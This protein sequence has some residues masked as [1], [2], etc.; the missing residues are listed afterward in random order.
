MS[1]VTT[2]T[3]R[4]RW[5]GSART[6]AS[7]VAYSLLSRLSILVVNVATGII[8]ARTLGPAGR[9]AAAAMT[10]WPLVIPA[11]L[12]LGV[13]TALRY[14]IRRQ[15]DAAAEF[16]AAAIAVGGVLGAVAAVTGYAIVPH[17]LAHYPPTVVGFAQWMMLFAPLM[18]FNA[19]LQ[20]FYE[21]QGDFRRSNAMIY[22]PPILT[23]VGL[24]GLY[25]FHRLSPYA[26]A[27]VYEVPFAL[28]TIATLVSLRRYLRTPK[29]VIDRIGSLLHY[30][31]RAYGIDILN[32]LA[33]Q[34]DQAMVVGLLSVSN[35]GLYAVAVNGSRVLTVLAS[36]F[37]SVLFPRASGLE[38]SDAVLLVTRSARIVFASTS[39]AAL[40]FVLALPVLISLAYGKEYAAVVGVTRWLTIAALFAATTA[41]LSQ[42]F[43]ATGR[44]GVVTLLQSAGICATVPLML[45]L[46][47]KHGLVGAAY[48]VDISNGVR[49]ALV[50]LA[51]PICLHQPVPSLLPTR[52]DVRDA[53]ASLR[54]VPAA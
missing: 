23:L 24:A 27:L 41:T 35:F 37:N 53:I 30:G 29:R 45:L 26:V 3:A 7:S 19:T 54:R 28:M 2:L 47:P 34:I 21:S 8:V 52:R 17:V 12:T 49:L 14:K 1:L 43:M 32:T 5:I 9:G 44:P 13:P 38:A 18:L 16:F 11:L 20:A 36:S 40:A 25:L 31:F 22:I 50:I 46:I 51:Y 39:L 10:L 48:A 6:P 33:T 42:A 15:P 4:A